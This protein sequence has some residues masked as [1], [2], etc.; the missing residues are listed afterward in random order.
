MED[1]SIDIFQIN[2]SK[3]RVFQSILNLSTYHEGQKVTLDELIFEN[4][5]M[6]D[7]G[8]GSGEIGLLLSKRKQAA[9]L[10]QADIQDRRESVAK[11][12]SF[13]KL[14]RNIPPEFQDKLFG[15]IDTILLVDV[16]DKVGYS[17]LTKQESQ[18]ILLKTLH[19]LLSEN[20][21]IIVI[22]QR[23]SNVHSLQTSQ[24]IEQV[25]QYEKLRPVVAFFPNPISESQSL[26]E[27]IKLG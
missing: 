27:K 23:E 14:P 25:M 4:G 18:V 9:K 7:L 22:S 21:K 6:L 19:E 11:T 26:K 8:C 2:P 5:V 20:G 3:E 1:Y 16:L 17:H 13:I 10:F 15:S 12:D 24:I